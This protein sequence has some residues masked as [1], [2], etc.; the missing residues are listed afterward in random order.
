MIRV[1]VTR[2]RPS[3]FDTEMSHFFKI[4]PHVTKV[5]SE[6]IIK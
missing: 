4:P 3:V 6:I 5:L 1:D 2:D